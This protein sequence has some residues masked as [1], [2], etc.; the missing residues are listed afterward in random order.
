MKDSISGRGDCPGHCADDREGEATGGTVYHIKQQGYQWVPA[1]LTVQVGDTVVW[2]FDGQHNLLEGTGWG[3]C[4]PAAN[5]FYAGYGEGLTMTF[6]TP[7]SH[8]FYC[9]PHCGFGM[10]GVITVV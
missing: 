9:D 10:E 3:E 8:P 2:S 1:V 4:A 5:G 7:G 6:V